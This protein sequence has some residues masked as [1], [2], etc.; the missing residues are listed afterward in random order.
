VLGLS[1]DQSNLLYKAALAHD[2]GYLM[3]DKDELQRIVSKPE[4]TEE[5]FG[6]IQSHAVKGP[7]YFSDIDLPEE[8]KQALL[9]HHERNDGT[10]YPDGLKK[11]QIPLFAKIISV[12]ETF[13]SLVSKR[14][15]RDKHSLEHALAILK[16]GTRSKFDSDIVDALCKVASTIGRM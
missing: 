10:G 1:N 8:F 12:A 15:Y 3:L 9:Y 13:A 14:S 11:E 16:D 7:Q 5:E 6:F 2:C 4:I